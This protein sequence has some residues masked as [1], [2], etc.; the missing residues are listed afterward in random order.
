VVRP[1]KLL[2][3]A[4]CAV[5]CLGAG[6]WPH[7]TRPPYSCG[8]PDRPYQYRSSSATAQALSTVAILK[9]RKPFELG[10]IP[11]AWK[12]K[13]APPL[14]VRAQVK[15]YQLSVP[16]LQV[17]HC[18]LSRVAFVLHE[19]GAWTLSLR[20]EQNVALGQDAKPAFATPPPDGRFSEHLK[21]NQ[22]FVRVRC[23]GLYPLEEKVETSTGKPALFRVDPDPFWVQRGEPYDFWRRGRCADCGSFFDL[24][25]RVEIEFFYR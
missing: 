1:G 4:A 25:D 5:L 19:D 6:L 14:V 2:L 23:Y 22:F 11:E 13:A 15:V 18:A 12:D 21:R 8:V 7:R 20:A 3:G 10:A 24:I 9:E 16:K 17:D